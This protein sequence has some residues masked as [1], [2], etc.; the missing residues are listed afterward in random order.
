MTARGCETPAD[1]DRRRSPPL[2]AQNARIADKKAI[3][4]N[5]PGPSIA[6]HLNFSNNCFPKTGN[7]DIIVSASVNEG[8]DSASHEDG[9]EPSQTSGAYR[10][11]RRRP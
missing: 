3:G 10:R 1:L 7:W 5:P 9:G 8:V 11:E 6:R 2:M 4:G